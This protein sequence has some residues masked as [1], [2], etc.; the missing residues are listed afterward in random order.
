MTTK[1]QK[2]QPSEFD[3]GA[4]CSPQQN[5]LTFTPT[6]TYDQW[7]AVGKTLRRIEGAVSWWLGD[8]WLHGERAYGDM[9]SQEAKDAV[10]DETGHA[11]DTVR[12]YAYV[13]E[14]FKPDNRFA[15]LSYKHHQI[16]A[17]IDDESKRTEWLKTAAAEKLSTRELK[18]SILAGHVVRLEDLHKQAENRVQLNLIQ[19]VVG[20]ARL[21]LNNVAPKIQWTPALAERLEADV[22]QPLESIL[23]EIKTKLRATSKNI[24]IL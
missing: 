23:A 8:W 24:D 15:N 19:G 14:R 17:G 1:L 2:K 4:I 3:F 13:A 5:A 7:A 16:A 20:Q 21:W 18:A 12:V 9:A 11:Y 6:A 22:I 10:L